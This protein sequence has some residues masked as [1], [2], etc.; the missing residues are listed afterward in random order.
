MATAAS[1]STTI[2]TRWATVGVVVGAGTV[3]ALQ[4]GKAAI[5]TP[6]LQTDLGLGLAAAGWLTGIFAVLGLVG[7][8]PAG[9]LVARAGDR[10]VL[11]LGL[12]AIVLGTVLGA[13]A[14]GRFILFGS[15]AIEGFGFLLVSVAGPAILNRVATPGQRN[16]ALS[17][18]SCVMPAGM[19]LIMLVGAYFSNWRTLWWSNAGLAA[20]AIVAGAAAIPAA[21]ARATVS[22]RC[23]GSGALRVLTNDRSLMLS[24]CF[25][26]YNLMFFA[27][28]SF[29]PVLLMER[30]AVQHGAA[31][32]L[33]ALAIGSNMIGNLAAGYLLARGAGRS[34]LLA[35]AYVTMGLAG[36]GIFVQVFGET[37]TFLLCI[38]F[39]GVGGLI[40]ATLISSAP[41]LAPSPA[42]APVVIGLLMQGSNLGQVIGPVAVGGA[43]QSHG[44]SAAA[45]IVLVAA[46]LACMTASM[47]RF[48]K[49]Q[50]KPPPSP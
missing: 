20:I 5:A 45:A 33:S 10:R 11:L 23:P 4:A 12:V 21:P 3:A 29:L 41:L 15:R 2:G 25:A 19:A 36:V 48:D 49:K 26:L 27:L 24:L 37:S 30:M 7:G 22:S 17:L 42:L 14:P 40:P 18:W 39:S 44:W 6:V 13:T 32:V 47:I 31:G 46:T 1:T 16:M 8:I 34:A 35:G 28:F 38:L 9:A 43:I 50:R